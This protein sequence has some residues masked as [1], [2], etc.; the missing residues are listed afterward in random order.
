MKI[1]KA[2]I[3]KFGCLKNK[4]IDF[5]DGLNTFIED[6][7][8]GKTTTASFIKA[9][10]F[11]MDTV[12]ATSKKENKIP[13]REHYCPFGETSFGGTL[14]IEVNYE[15]YRIEKTFD[16]KS[17]TKDK[18]KV[19][20]S[21]GNE[22]LKGINLGEHFFGIDRES[23]ERTAF[24]SSTDL[25]V[26]RTDSIKKKLYGIVEGTEENLSYETLAIKIDEKIKAI[27][28]PGNRGSKGQIDIKQD[29]IIDLK[30]Q[31]KAIEELENAKEQKLEDRK[32]IK[33]ELLEVENTLSASKDQEIIEANWEAYELKLSE[34]EEAKKK[35]EEILEKYPNGF[36]LDED[37]E[38][39]NKAITEKETQDSIC[40]DKVLLPSEEGQLEQLKKKYPSGPLSTLDAS[41]L[42]DQAWKVNQFQENTKSSLTKEDEE[43]LNKLSLSFRE[44]IPEDSEL[45]ETSYKI[46]Q[47]NRLEDKLAPRSVSVSERYGKLKKEFFDGT[48]SEE[49]LNKIEGLVT[50]HKENEAKKRAL[51]NNLTITIGQNEKPN[52][53]SKIIGGS[54]G[55][56][57]LALAVVGAIIQNIPLLI[58]GAVLA[59]IGVLAFF[60]KLG[61][62]KTITTINQ[63]AQK[64]LNEID[65]A[66]APLQ[67]ELAA[68]FVRFRISGS[69]FANNLEILKSDIKEYESILEEEKKASE[70]KRQDEETLKTLK[71]EVRSFFERYLIKEDD[72]NLAISSLSTSVSEYQRLIALKEESDK[73]ETTTKASLEETLKSIDELL[74]KYSL[75]RESNVFEQAK[76]IEIESSSFRELLAKESS[77]KKAEELVKEATKTIEEKLKK[78]GI[79]ENENLSEI[80]ESLLSDKMTLTKAEED[81]GKLT[82]SAASYKEEKSLEDTK[83]Q[84]IN[85]TFDKVSL[86]EKRDELNK[87]LAAKDNEI[88]MD[89]ARIDEKPIIEE[90]I[91]NTLE[92]IDELQA[93]HGVLE[94]TKKYLDQAEEVLRKKYI[95][96]IEKH[97]EKY[98]NEI[99][100]AIGENAK[101][102]MDFNVTFN[103]NGI[104]TK[105]DHLSEGQKACLYLCIRFAVMDEMYKD[106]KPFIT[107]DDPLIYLDD[108]NIG[109]ALNT[110]KSLS[111]NNQVL[112][113]T[114]HESRKPQ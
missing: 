80:R 39:L 85:K 107:L 82:S 104:T 53:L 18:T 96:P 48:P 92:S 97:F 66:N 73:K 106:E 67:E 15:T 14:T 34:I 74:A 105:K 83:P 114:C 2:E 101:I 69:D 89:D 35:K 24:I 21:K 30:N 62:P 109:S 56:L 77:Y 71:E 57:G 42:K 45:K 32:K 26:N 70:E 5:T 88:E 40:K 76:I 81:I 13:D 75:S 110:I 99:N 6:N 60:I 61:G 16:I 49:E 36:P 58:V 27:K 19:F 20:D 3:N 31:L 112:Y 46:S 4:V 47:I 93:K 12:R 51:T 44:G 7:G 33:D 100:K 59:V 78:M 87:E 8:S 95:G 41:S 108:K 22:V 55:G 111:N 103:N 102:G 52:N 72:Y 37:I 79:K 94:M 23:F 98:A 10:L 63:D 43:S 64:S 29:E 86:I 54:I 25:D 90:K 17:E 1:I 113:Y 65:I 50:K 11:G 84:L 91:K 68:F 38:S 9:M 28:R